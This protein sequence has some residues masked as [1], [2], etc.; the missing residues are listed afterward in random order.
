MELLPGLLLLLLPALLPLATRSGA[1]PRAETGA[2]E[3]A[4]GASWVR[5][6]LG[7]AAAPCGA[8]HEGP[9]RGVVG[10]WLGAAGVPA[11][12]PSVRPPCP[13]AKPGYCYHIA[14]LEDPLDEDCGACRGDAS[15]SRCAV[16]ADC[17]G[18]T[19][20]CPSKC[21]DTCQEPVLGEGW[22]PWRQGSAAAGGHAQGWAAGGVRQT[23]PQGTPGCPQPRLGPAAPGGTVLRTGERRG[24]R[25][26]G[27]GAGGCRAAAGA[28][29]WVARGDQSW[30]GSLG[31]RQRRTWQRPRPVPWLSLSPCPQTS[32]TCP[33]SAGAARRFS[34]ASSSTP[35]AS[36][37]RSSSTAAAAA[38]G[39]TS[40][41][42][43]S[44]SRPA[45]TSVAS[46]VPRAPCP[47]PRALC[48]MSCALR[49]VLCTLCPVPCTLCPASHALRPVPRAL[50]PVL[51]LVGAHAPGAAR[52]PAPDPHLSVAGA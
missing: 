39:T 26:W 9:G 2:G 38:T 14:G 8:G 6:A 19:K 45:P 7:A 5:D 47:V 30:A 49:P 40:R 52:G 3:C 22:V 13:A 29:G 35:P 31:P 50:C 11:A 28:K 23:P 4:R 27:R 20:C 10:V 12:L 25:G 15:C 21:G 17:P 51:Q 16:D 36:S 43:A 33:R 42:G 18:A 44:A 37:A 1:A 34:G 46:P 48:P 24:C 32:A 41:P